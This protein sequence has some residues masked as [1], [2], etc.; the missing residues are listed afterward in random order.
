MIH[1]NTH[2]GPNPVQFK[3]KAANYWMDLSESLSK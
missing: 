1:I 3:L 2:S